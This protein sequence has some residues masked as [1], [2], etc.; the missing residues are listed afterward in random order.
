MAVDRIYLAEHCAESGK[1]TL[2]L[3]HKRC[4]LLSLSL[5]TKP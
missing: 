1:E 3:I 4:P 5:Q 2:I